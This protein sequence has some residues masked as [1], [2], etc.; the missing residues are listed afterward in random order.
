MNANNAAME[1]LTAG[2]RWRQ[3]ITTRLVLETHGAPMKHHEMELSK[4][5]KRKEEEKEVGNKN[6][7]HDLC[8]A[9]FESSQ[10]DHLPLE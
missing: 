2:R 3:S 1:D 9:V 7:N 10:T 5:K 4:K 8:I 6:R